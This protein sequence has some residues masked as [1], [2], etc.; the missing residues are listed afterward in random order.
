M[1]NNPQEIPPLRR[2]IRAEKHR[3]NH[4][5]PSILRRRQVEVRTGLC[6]SAIYAAVAAGTFPKPIR[7]GNSRS[8]G[9]IESEVSDWIEAQI[10]ISRKTAA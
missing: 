8:V 1:A 7:L 9:W 4:K 5:S 3:K 10:R 2:L 6:R